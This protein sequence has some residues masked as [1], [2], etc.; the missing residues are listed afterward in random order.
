MSATANKSSASSA[1]NAGPR[2]AWGNKSVSER[3]AA[4]AT[5]SSSL[6]SSSSSSSPSPASAPKSKVSA[7]KLIPAIEIKTS[8]AYEDED[9][10]FQS[11]FHKYSEYAGENPLY[12]TIQ[13]DH[14]I[15][16]KDIMN[17]VC[18]E[19]LAITE[20][21]LQAVGIW[22]AKKLQEHYGVDIDARPESIY[23]NIPAN[24]LGIPVRHG[25]LHFADARVI[26]YMVK[27]T[28]GEER[29]VEITKE[30]EKEE[31]EEV[32]AKEEPISAWGE[33]TSGSWADWADCSFSDKKYKTV[34]YEPWF[35]NLTFVFPSYRVATARA[36]YMKERGLGPQ[37]LEDVEADITSNLDLVLGRS[38]A[39]IKPDAEGNIYDPYAL[40]SLFKSYAQ[41]VPNSAYMKLL[42]EVY[43]HFKRYNTS[44]SVYHPDATKDSKGKKIFHQPVPLYPLCSWS[45]NQKTIFVQFGEN[46]A[47]ASD[48]KKVSTI[49][50][51]SIPYEDS[52]TR[53][54]SKL[55]GVLVFNHAIMNERKDEHEKVP[56][57]YRYASGFPFSGHA[58]RREDRRNDRR[59]DGKREYKPR[60]EF[61][62]RDG[63]ANQRSRK[64]E[65]GEESNWRQR[66]S[67][68]PA[69]KGGFSSNSGGGFQGLSEE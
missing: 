46:L 10:N 2:A 60:G 61:P 57:T 37:D 33:S 12:V 25:Q 49:M 66:N 9:C 31:E 50:T 36:T 58:I 68:V 30:S 39:T 7:S 32:S 27:A 53:A 26:E 28:M 63:F 35:P 24:K 21:E 59:E 40:S 1:A 48:A 54:P 62:R 15:Q 11:D 13:S 20:D 47:D 64:F 6:S 23:A 41:N 42:D 8:P 52:Q 51:Y 4:L 43:N 14:V 45:K 67:A 34:R 69:K 18:K 55:E 65:G 44:K 5:S 22:I 16:V 3:N 17:S 19:K 56:H 38:F 29:Q